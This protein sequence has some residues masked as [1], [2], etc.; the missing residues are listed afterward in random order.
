MHGVGRPDAGFR[1]ISRE[2]NELILR[3]AREMKAKRVIQPLDDS[4]KHRAIA[5]LWVRAGWS[6]DDAGMPFMLTAPPLTAEEADAVLAEMRRENN[7]MR[8]RHGLEV[9]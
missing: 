1:V 5:R 9:R 3:C 6:L 4:R 8:R 7:Q 2:L